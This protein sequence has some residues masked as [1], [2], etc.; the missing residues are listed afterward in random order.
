MSAHSPINTS[1]DSRQSE[2]KRFGRLIAGG[3]RFSIV[4]GLRAGMPLELIAEIL[5]IESKRARSPRDLEPGRAFDWAQDQV[6]IRTPQH[7]KM[8]ANQRRRST[9]SCRK[10][11]AASALVTKVSAADAGPTTLRSAHES[12]TRLLKNAMAMKKIPP[13]R[14]PLDATRTMMAKKP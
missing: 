7:T 8:V 3:V 2:S 11:L 9:F 14:T 13:K 1:T 4:N 5:I 6:R 10:N 12:P